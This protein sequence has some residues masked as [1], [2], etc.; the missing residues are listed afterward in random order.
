LKIDGCPNKYC[1]KVVQAV[2]LIDL[3]EKGL[4]PVAGGA[5]DQSVW[6]TEAATILN[7]EDA[8]AKALLNGN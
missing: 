7:N 4:P 6:F 3:F 2:G 8:K 1:R 5:L